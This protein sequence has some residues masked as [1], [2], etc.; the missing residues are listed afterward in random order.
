MQSVN[1]YNNRAHGY[2]WSG[3]HVVFV[4]FGMILVGYVW[5]VNRS[6]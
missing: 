4:G 5:L 2:E 3:I 6:G 1:C